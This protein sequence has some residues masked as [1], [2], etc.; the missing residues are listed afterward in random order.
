[1]GKTS[2]IWKECG[3]QSGEDTEWK[4]QMEENIKK[5]DIVVEER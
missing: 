4:T 2:G 1:M 3:T 5:A